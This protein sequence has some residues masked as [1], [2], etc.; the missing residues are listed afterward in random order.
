MSSGDTGSSGDDSAGIGF[1]TDPDGGYGRCGKK[2]PAGTQALTIECSL[3]DQDCCPGD[4]C[5]AWDNDAGDTWNATR[6]VPLDP[7]AGQVGEP[8]TAEA[9]AVSGADSC[10]IGL[11]CWEVDA[12]TLEGTC[13]QY[14]GEEGPECVGKGEVC[15]RFND[16]FL[17]LC[18]HGCDPLTP[19]CADGLGCYPSGQEFVCLREGERAHLDGVFHTECPAGTF[20]APPGVEG[21]VGGEPCCVSFCDVTEPEA[22]GADVEC[23]PYFEEPLPEQLAVG[24]CNVAS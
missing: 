6:C 2:L 1:I 10:D 15:T 23:L 16:G 5:R 12:E 24:Y 11:M 17:P 9:S 14:C 18:L 22:C 8:C 13:A 19:Q 3:Q 20:A 7:D 4:A 21:C